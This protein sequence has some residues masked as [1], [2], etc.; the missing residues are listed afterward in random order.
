MPTPNPLKLLGVTE[1]LLRCDGGS[2]VVC[3]T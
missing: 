3:S 1:A 2:S